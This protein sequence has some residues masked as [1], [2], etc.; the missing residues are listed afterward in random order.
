MRG[1]TLNVQ[2][3]EPDQ[4]NGAQADVGVLP[5]TL[6]QFLQ[7]KQ[8]EASGLVLARVSF[9][10]VV[11]AEGVGLFLWGWKLDAASQ[12]TR[13]MLRAEGIG[14]VDLLELDYQP[15]K[16]ADVAR[17][18]R[19]AEQQPDLADEFCGFAAFV[20][21]L[22]GATTF[23]ELVVECR[24][25]DGTEVAFRLEEVPTGTD[26]V[27]GLL[28]QA[29]R[30][31]FER[32][33]AESLRSLG[34]LWYPVIAE[35]VEGWPAS[36]ESLAV[37]HCAVLD[38][39][40]LLLMASRPS[41]DLLAWARRFILCTPRGDMA[42]LEWRVFGEWFIA[43]AEGIVARGG[44]E[45]TLLPVAE[46]GL[47]RPFR[48]SVDR[49]L[50]VPVAEARRIVTSL[51]P[52]AAEPRKDGAVVATTGAV[53][54]SCVQVTGLIGRSLVGWAAR[55]GAVPVEIAVE[56]DGAAV[57]T[58]RA[59]RLD[60]AF[61]LSSAEPDRSFEWVLPE[62]AFDG[63]THT[64]R[65][66]AGEGREVVE[67][68]ETGP[69]VFDA[70]VEDFSGGVVYGWVLERVGSFE[71]VRVEAFIDDE[72]LG[73]FVCDRRL[74]GQLDIRL[75]RA[76][77]FEIPVPGRFLD[78]RPH[79]FR[80]LVGGARVARAELRSEVRGAIDRL[81]HQHLTGWVAEYGPAG[82][83]PVEVELA[84]EGQA[85]DLRV[86]R[87]FRPD[88]GAVCGI[89]YDI[90]KFTRELHSFEVLF[91][92]RGTDIAVAGTPVHF[93]RKDDQIRALQGVLSGLRARGSELLP[94]ER[95]LRAL[96]PALIAETRARPEDHRVLGD[97]EPGRSARSA[98]VRVIVPVYGGFRETR[99]CI[100]SVLRHRGDNQV[101]HE[102]LL[103][104]DC[105][106]DPRLR[107]AL[108][109]YGRLDGVRLLVNERNLGFVGS[110]N[111]ALS[112]ST[113]HDV[114]LLNA[115]A[116]VHGN[117]L[118][119]LSQAAHGSAEI[120]TVT[121]FSN[122]A[123]ICSYP[124]L[125]SEAEL[126]EG[127]TLAELD[128]VC[129]RVNAG[130]VVEL[131]TGVGFCMYMRADALAQVGLL[132]E[133]WGRGYGEE[134]D[135]C[136][137]ARDRGWKHVLASDVFVQHLGGVSFGQE[138][139]SAQLEKNLKA[140]AEKYPEYGSD[141]QG[142][143]QRDPPRLARNRVT[144]ERLRERLQREGLGT[145]LFVTHGLG[146]GIAV[147]CDSMA[148]ELLRDR[149]A[150]IQLQSDGQR[151][152]LSYEDVE[153]EYRAAEFHAALRDLKRLAPR[154]VHFHSDIG[155]EPDIWS[156]PRALGCPSYVT[157]HDYLPVCPRVNMMNA[158][159]SYCGGPTDSTVC[160]RC[161]GSNGAYPLLEERLEALGDD[162]AEWRA[163][164][165]RMLEAAKA[166][167][168]PDEDVAERMRRFYPKLT[169]TVRPHPSRSGG[170]KVRL[171]QVSPGEP[172]RIAIIGAIGQHKGY[173]L[174]LRCANDALMRRLPLSFHVF[175]YTCDDASL[176]K[177]D[178]VHLSGSYL[179]EQLP[180][181]LQKARC[182]VALFLSRWP[183]TYSYTLSEAI[184]CGL[185]PVVLD[186]GAPARR[187]RELGI[188]KVLALDATATQINDALLDV[189]PLPKKELTLKEGRYDS[190]LKHYYG[191]S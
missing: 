104:D 118:D 161:I 71:P 113:G 85:T 60:T 91:T 158:A 184:A 47:R 84:I 3:N 9:D 117:W 174:L 31:V 97:P 109:R 154:L 119:R 23:G 165:G 188:G 62:Q 122:N 152:T 92:L 25:S 46:T 78:G 66:L 108:Q 35:L 133:R 176:V 61:G 170:G 36:E 56:L 64:V 136:L 52:A 132:D 153:V 59:D 32:V 42:A 182:Q 83:R 26:A 139:K 41:P 70:R 168:V 69:G 50:A 33:P 1:S 189:L 103:V 76:C 150:A 51:V 121:P 164:Y 171:S 112:E 37:D 137:R 98:S 116:V 99:E 44:E 111:R 107:Q 65:V 68:L 181:L 141:I 81:G 2:G 10:H 49:S 135:W 129:G 101:V 55:L 190:M 157:V 5:L 75:G 115:D 19:P 28:R 159:Y 12:L 163:H 149:I 126:P 169:F 29:A 40:W 16:R 80:A 178:N 90:T 148:E 110:V 11:A 87:F 77:G 34:R 88:V 53:G 96:L 160:N 187:L 74:G 82:P 86:T 114:V 72:A 175:G 18:F 155:F 123:T 140:L 100:D 20:P 151:F 162:V 166:V 8:S 120:A 73:A 54:P 95:R 38:G 156:L 79:Q 143:I 48:V 106:P 89:Q 131:P 102:L 6:G 177:N 185:Q 21:A 127:V 147:H 172:L 124:A 138:L 128:S 191:V 7:V 167:F 39:R 24:T 94:E 134:N 180:D 30:F 22:D 186:I 142:F 105:G 146:G 27:A 179:P 43:V 17:A 67:E 63:K 14:E 130:E 173:E 45:L 13:V 93:V 15:V 125:N 183:E 4:A 145:V 144:V 57:G 58:T